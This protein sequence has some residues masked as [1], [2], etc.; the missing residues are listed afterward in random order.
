M[1]RSFKKADEARAFLRELLPVGSRLP[2]E[3]V[4]RIA[5]QAGIN[6]HTLDAASCGWVTKRK[7]VD[8]SDGRQRHFWWIEPQSKPK[9]PPEPKP[10]RCKPDDAFRAGY[11][12]ALGDLE[13][14]C[15]SALKSRPIGSKIRNEALKLLRSMVDEK[16]NKAKES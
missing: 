9:P 8:P 15:R 6:L 13:Y 2:G 1:K 7:A 14:A 12:A 5:E 11:L 3:A 16:A 10:S 4:R